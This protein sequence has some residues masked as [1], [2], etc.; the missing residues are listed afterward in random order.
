MTVVV[1]VLVE[2]NENANSAKHYVWTWPVGTKCLTKDTRR[3]RFFTTYR[4]RHVFESP[5][6]PETFHRPLTS[7]AP[8]ELLPRAA[9]S[10]CRWNVG[11]HGSRSVT[12]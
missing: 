3:R 11:G 2:N 4:T 9:G 12:C 1:R 10:G 6:S 5:R 7:P 8:D